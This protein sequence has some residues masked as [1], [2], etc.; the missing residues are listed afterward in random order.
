M[1]RALPTCCAALLALLL[2]APTTISAQ[3]DEAETRARLDALQ[4]QIRRLDR[5]LGSARGERERLL[6]QLKTAEMALAHLQQQMSETRAAVD[7]TERELAALQAR[8]QE[9]EQQ[10]QTQQARIGSE[11]ETAWKMGRQEQIKLL[12]SQEDPHTLARNMAYYRYFYQSRNRMIDAFRSTLVE[13]AAVGEG[14]DTRRQQLDARQAQ[15][16]SEQRS[17]ETTRT[18]R[19]QAAERLAADISAK[20]DTLAQLKRDQK[21]LEQLLETIQ[22][23]TIDMPLPE[24]FQTFAKARGNM[25]W[26]VGGKPSNRFGR[27]RNDGKMTWQGVNIPA[28]AGT[29]VHAIHHGRVVY[30][31]WFGGS[32]L[33]LIVDHGEGYMSLYAHNQTLLREVGEWVQAGTPIGNVGNSGG[34][35]QPALYFEIRHQGKPVDPARWCKG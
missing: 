26:P 18:D 27:A 9:L 17:L 34:L 29:V 1:R 16:A 4:A 3:G 8:Q 22:R 6:S 25:P 33:L 28:R 2:A 10:R 15:L 24:N 20:G 12:L 19:R 23:A 5:E 32:G 7:T 30:A 14:I 13:L 31:D 21:K 11:L 35:D